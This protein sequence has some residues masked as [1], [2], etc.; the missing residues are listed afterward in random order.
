M[1]TATLSDAYKDPMWFFFLT[2]FLNMSETPET[3]NLEAEKKPER[4]EL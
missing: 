4:C 3:S 2:A 1:I